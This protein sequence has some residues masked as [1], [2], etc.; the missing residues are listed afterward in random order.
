M[1]KERMRRDT[2]WRLENGGK[3]VCREKCAVIEQ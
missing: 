2:I 3:C 1:L